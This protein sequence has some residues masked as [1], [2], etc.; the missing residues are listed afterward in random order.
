MPPVNLLI[1]PASSLCN[2]RC[3]Y[4]F[5]KDV[6][7]NRAVDSYGIMTEET[8]EQMV[9]KTFAYAEGFAAF[10]FQGGEPTLAG[11]DFYKKLIDLQKKYN[12]K[13]LPVYNSIQTNGYLIDEEWAEFLA[14]HNFLTGL[15]LDGTREIHDSLRVDAAQKGTYDRVT[16][17]AQLLERFGAQFNILCVVSNF[18]ARHPKK[19]YDSLKKYKYLQFIPCLDDFDGG[20]NRFSLTNDRYANFLKVT[21]SEYY[22]DFVSG[23][24][25][26]VRN[27][28]NYI[29]ML[30]GNPPESCAMNGVCSCYFV[31]EGN[32]DV[33]PC[34]FYV[35]DQWRLGNIHTDNFDQMA[36]SERAKEFV[37][38]SQ[39]VD[40]HCR[41]C[42]WL[43]LCRGGCRRNREPFQDGKPRLNIYC[44]SYRSFFAFAYPQMAE[45]ARML[46]PGK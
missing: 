32:G 11:L 9:I 7:E 27:F 20:T 12:E 34:D 40:P 29:Q 8:L 6:T 38:C 26:S 17:A 41:S 1:K 43:Q 16:K 23:N 35:L 44:E 14:K 13:G 37:R 46:S 5:Y 21:F 19:V 22:R 18:A 10:V 28:D 42:R 36:Q 2:M 15:S 24:Y 31:I 45:M 39:Y 25:V 4:C 33:F 3:K 30:R